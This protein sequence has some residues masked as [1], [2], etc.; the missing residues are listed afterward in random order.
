ML[1]VLK[2]ITNI[3]SIYTRPEFQIHCKDSEITSYQY[4]CIVLLIITSNRLITLTGALD[5]NK[6]TSAILNHLDQID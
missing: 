4:S 6:D 2:P 5:V 3:N 1:S